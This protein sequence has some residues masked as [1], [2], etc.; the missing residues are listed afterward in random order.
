[1]KLRRHL[2]ADYSPLYF[3]AA[4]GNGGLAVTF[5]IYL[6]FMVPHPQTP[7]ITFDALYPYVSAA[8]LPVQGLIGAALLAMAYFGLRHLRFL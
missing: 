1:M 8:S 4:L 3:L 7:I 6:M 2:G 5:F